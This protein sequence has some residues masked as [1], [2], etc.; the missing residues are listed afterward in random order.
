MDLDNEALLYMGF[1]KEELLQSDVEEQ[2]IDSE[3]FREKNFIKE[4]TDYW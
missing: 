1:S 2:N 4:I 3:V